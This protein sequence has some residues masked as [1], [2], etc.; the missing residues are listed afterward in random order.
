MFFYHNL[1][2]FE[3]FQSD[4]KQKIENKSS[5]IVMP[6]NTKP[7]SADDT[8]IFFTGRNYETIPVYD[9]ANKQFCKI[10][11]WLIANKLSLNVEKTNHVVFRTSNFK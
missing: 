9:C 8:H 10:D 11:R 3:D 6:V 7:S 2:F 5:S 1:G 4:F